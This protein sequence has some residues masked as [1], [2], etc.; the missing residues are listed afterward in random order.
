M[1]PVPLATEA[2]ENIGGQLPSEA[3]I[4]PRPETAAPATEQLAG[5][6]ATA[7]ASAPGSPA[8][9]G[10]GQAS[11]EAGTN[12]GRVGPPQVKLN[13]AAGDAWAIYAT[14]N[15]LSED[16]ISIQP[17]ITIKSNGPSGLKAR[18]DAV[19]RVRATGEIAI[20]EMK[21]SS[22]APLTPNQRVVYPELETHGGTVVGKGKAPYVGGTQ[23]PPT[24]V[25]IIRKP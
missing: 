5:G 21:A 16:Q 6:P 10:D 20:S 24:R 25:A 7:S 23:I 22:T 8:P 15:M 1:P 18:A 19:G 17:Q 9:I 4:T 3:V 13:K 2:A 11:A 12:A 14:D